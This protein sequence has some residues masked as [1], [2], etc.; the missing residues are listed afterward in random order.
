M[1]VPI[2]AVMPSCAR[3]EISALESTRLYTRTSS[4]TPSKYPPLAR[5]MVMAD[6]EMPVVV[7]ITT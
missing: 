1:V 4:I 6:A 5:P 3:R 2:F 7:V